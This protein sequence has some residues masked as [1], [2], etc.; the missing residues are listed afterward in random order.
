MKEIIQTTDLSKYYGD[1]KAVDSLNLSVRK[2]EIY[3]FLGLNG[4]GKTTTIRML[5]GMINPTRGQA[6][7][8]E[9]RIKPNNG[10]MWNDIGYLVEIPYSYPNLTVRENLNIIRR[11]RKLSDRN[12]VDDIIDLMEIRQY[13]NRRAKNLSLGNKQRLGLAKAMVHRPQIL[14][15]DEPTNGFDPAGIYDVREMLCNL[16]KNEGV[17]IFISSHILG[18]ISRFANR[19]GIIHQ[20]SLIQEI[21]T[22]ELA[23]LSN[24]RLNVQCSNQSKAFSILQQNGYLKLNINNS[25]LEISD[26]MAL[27]HPENVAKL[28]VEAQCLPS[29]LKVEEED[30]ESYFLR[31]IK[32][33][34]QLS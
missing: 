17:T 7:I 11:L 19:I 4:A 3:G 20:G 26:P 27:E 32:L 14:I 33:K 31:T 23:S 13:A 21:T 8:N 5:L 10:A 22:D 18:E 6:Y 30:L 12:A 16:A 25:Y 2:G 9:K 29:L 34:N 15:L 28:L 1:V 24:K